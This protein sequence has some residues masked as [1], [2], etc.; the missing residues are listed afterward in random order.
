M[1]STNSIFEKIT[2]TLILS[3]KQAYRNKPRVHQSS[4]E[5]EYEVHSTSSILKKIIKNNLRHFIDITL[6]LHAA[7]HAPQP[8]HILELNVT[9]FARFK[10][11]TGHASTHPT[12]A[13]PQVQLVHLPS[14]QQH[15]L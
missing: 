11:P 9:V 15:F 12:Q 10:A 2:I 14:F 6:C 13:L 7:T 3:P 5:N 8:I 1:H 4:Y